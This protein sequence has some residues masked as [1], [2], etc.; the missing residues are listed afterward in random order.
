[1]GGYL[2]TSGRGAGEW[3]AQGGTATFTG[4]EL[5]TRAG[6]DINLSGGTLD[7]RDG[8]IRQSWLRGAD[9]RLYELSRAP[10]DL[11]YTGLYKGFEQKHE[12]WGERATRTFYNPLIAPRQRFESGYTVGRD[13]GQLLVS[14]ERAALQGALT[15][16]VYQGPR[17]TDAAARPGRLLSIADRGGATRTMVVGQYLPRF[18]TATNR[19]AWGL[20]GISRQVTVGQADAADGE[21]VL[22]AAWLNQAGLGALKL[23]GADRVV[24]QQALRLAPGARPCCTR[25]GSPS[26][27]TCRRRAAASRPAMCSSR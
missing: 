21:I 14:T 10:G 19:L 4:G 5:V 27:R 9:G 24:V 18:D 13:A 2:A 23:A 17:Q 6:S 8:Y 26:T 12:R 20:S 11:L 1:M 22:D 3:L 16:E 15:G 7:V 25:P